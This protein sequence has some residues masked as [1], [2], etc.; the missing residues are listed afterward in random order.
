M[1]PVS[2]TASHV[3]VKFFQAA[4]ENLTFPEKVKLGLVQ[5]VKLVLQ[6]SI[7]SNRRTSSQCPWNNSLWPRLQQIYS[8]V[9]WRERHPTSMPLILLC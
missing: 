9:K 1:P 3:Q 8:Q 2:D 6:V 5:S 4:L 7:K